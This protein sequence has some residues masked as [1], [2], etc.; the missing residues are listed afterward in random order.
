[1]ELEKTQILYIFLFAILIAVA[2]FY[3]SEEDY[4]NLKSLEEIYN[5][6]IDVDNVEYENGVPKVVYIVWFGKN[7]SNNRLKALN[8]LVDSLKVPYILITEDNYMNFSVKETPIHKNFHHL[9]GNHKSDYLRAYLLNFYGG[10][11]HDIKYRDISWENEW[12]TFKDDNIWMKSCKEIKKSHIGYDVDRP[13]TKK[14]QNYYSQLGSM[15][16]VISRKE[17]PYTI[18]LLQKIEEKLDLHDKKLNLYP[19]EKNGGYYADR[20]FSKLKKE[21]KYPLRWLELMG[22]HFHL[23]MYEYKDNIDLTLPR[24]NMKGYK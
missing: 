15:C 4:S 1:M 23:L 11:Y 17:T 7:I 20:P 8:S 6:N 3:F 14:V 13:E 24:P 18:E 12:K 21:D 5:N 19:S 2:Y 22:E 9:S 16:W 10:G